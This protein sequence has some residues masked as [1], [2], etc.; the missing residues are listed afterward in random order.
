MTTPRWILVATTLLALILSTVNAQEARRVIVGQ[1]AGVG[2]WDPPV[3]FFSES[4]WI[5]MNVYD[6][7]VFSDRAE[8]TITGWLAE[9]WELQPDEVTWRMHLRQGVRFHN[10]YPFTAEDAAFSIQRIL[11]GSI[12][13]FQTFQT[14]RFIK[15]VRIVDEYTLDIVTPQPDPGFLSK[16]GST[17]CGVLSKRYVEEE[18]TE[19]IANFGMGTGPFRLVD[20]DRAQFVRLEA[21]DDYWGGRPAIDELI[22]RV[23]PEASTRV[24]ELLTGGIDIA[25]GIPP[26]EWSRI[27]NHPDLRMVHYL[28]DR[29]WLLSPAHTPPPGVDAVATSIPEIREAISLAIDRDELNDLVGG[30][31]VPTLTRLTPPIPGWDLV[32]PPLYNVNPFD[33][34]RARELMAQVG[35]PDVPGGPEI[36]LHGTFGQGVGQREIA[37]TIAAM[38]EDVGFQ[39]RLDIRDLT[40]FRETV[41]P[42]NNEELM[43]QTLGNRITDPWIFLF[44][45]NSLYG[46]RVFPRD[47]FSDPDVDALGIR[48]DTEMDPDARAQLVAEF[49]QM[50]AAR[51]ASIDL[52]HQADSIGMRSDL[53]WQPPT[54]GNLLFLNLTF[55]DD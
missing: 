19:A 36:V 50:V 48:A 38:L 51:H 7:L 49:A 17:G 55:A 41:H 31:G 24:A 42:G 33:P 46:E 25:P 20:Y 16:L 40:T 54:D 13:E 32:D 52:L 14:W 39:V 2:N 43:L 11:D 30:F 5:I 28:T 1:G 22:F 21:N 15:E 35:Y 8:G 37:E 53:V 23:I 45:Y 27:D 47:R 44:V 34:D 29:V 6:C 3:D 18:G 26:Q 9:S 4:E 10:G 12:Q